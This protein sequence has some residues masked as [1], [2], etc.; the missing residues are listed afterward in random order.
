MSDGAVILLDFGGTL[1][2]DGVPWED[3]FF[4]IHRQGGSRVSRAAFVTAFQQSERAMAELA[5]IESLGFRAMIHTQA[6]LLAT[7]L[8]QPS[9]DPDWVAD[10]FYLGSLAMVHRN[11]RVLETLAS[12]G[13][14]MAVVSNFTGNLDRCL[15]ELEL[16]RYFAVTVDSALVGYAKPDTRIFL[17]AA[18]ALGPSPTG[19]ACW[20][21]GDNPEADI[22][23]AAA[24]GYESAW[25]APAVRG[26]PAGLSPTARIESL[27][28][29]PDLLG[30]P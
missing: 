16:D 8:E 25:I 2:A 28:I 29:L 10:R 14:R 3:R 12:A 21:V 1:D 7:I 27:A 15:E 13:H 17:R 19:A 20:I 30:C 5:G 18:E 9:P 23:P 22:R 11:R 26:T 24:L 6:E 4:S